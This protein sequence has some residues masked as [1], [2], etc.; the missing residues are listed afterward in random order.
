MEVVVRVV[1]PEVRRRGLS[2]EEA[3]VVRSVYCE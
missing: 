2:A 1:D 3:G